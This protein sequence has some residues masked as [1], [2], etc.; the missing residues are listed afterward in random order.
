MCLTYISSMKIVGFVLRFHPVDY[1]VT[2]G[3]FRSLPVTSG[4]NRCHI[5]EDFIKLLFNDPL[6]TFKLWIY[7]VGHHS[8]N[9]RRKVALLHGLLFPISSEGSFICTNLPLRS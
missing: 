7:D 3:H 6:D 1:C 8:E 9:E 4:C 5:F 2:S